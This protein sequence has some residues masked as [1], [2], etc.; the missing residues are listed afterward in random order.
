MTLSI[1]PN[2][3]ETPRAAEHR[4]AEALRGNPPTGYATTAEPWAFG[5]VRVDG[6]SADAQLSPIVPGRTVTY[7][8]TFVPA[9]NERERGHHQRMD[10]L[11]QSLVHANDVL[12]FDP[13]G[14]RVFYREQYDGASALVRIAPLRSDHDATWVGGDPPPGRESIHDPRW[15]VVTGG[16]TRRPLP[17]RS[18]QLSLETVTVGAVAEYPTREAMVAAAQRNGF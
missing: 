13:P 12:T 1:L 10:T 8:C 3:S 15:A 7:T 11:A 4:Y 2:E 16:E 9:P 5:S 17:D 18:V 6:V 14:D